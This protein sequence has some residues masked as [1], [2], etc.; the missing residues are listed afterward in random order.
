MFAKIKSMF[1]KEKPPVDYWGMLTHRVLVKGEPVYSVF[2]GDR[3]QLHV[4]LYPQLGTVT[5]YVD[6]KEE[7]LLILGEEGIAVDR[8]VTGPIK[9]YLSEGQ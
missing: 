5:Y 2:F 7:G 6:N 4:E 8:G 1:I 9:E 3:C